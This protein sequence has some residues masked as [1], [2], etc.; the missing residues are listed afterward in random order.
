MK[1]TYI[2]G[3]TFLIFL[4]VS[5]LSSHEKILHIHSESEYF[6]KTPLGVIGVQILPYGDNKNGEAD[7][8]QAV[9]GR[10]TK[11]RLSMPGSGNCKM[12]LEIFHSEKNKAV[13]K[14]SFPSNHCDEIHSY[15]FYDAGPYEIRFTA[16]K[17]P[18][19]ASAVLETNV[20][21][22]APP[23]VSIANSM[24]LLLFTAALGIAA[25]LLFLRRK[26][27]FSKSMGKV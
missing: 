4:A 23:L 21:G 10:P 16:G 20:E 26:R 19:T 7:A 5:G 17:G 9:T 6:K 14:S 25:A 18:A 12:D 15:H 8:V 3:A 13:Y 1:N 11:I 2:P 27:G 24:S 22:F